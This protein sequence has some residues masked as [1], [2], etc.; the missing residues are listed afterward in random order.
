MRSRTEREYNK[1][2]RE[3]DPE[4]WNAL[5]ND[6]EEDKEND[7]KED[8]VDEDGGACVALIFWEFEIRLEVRDKRKRNTMLCLMEPLQINRRENY[9]IEL[10]NIN[11]HHE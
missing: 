6:F 10:R 7:H 4:D 2:N 11:I 8:E 5:A 9:W 3:E 1:K